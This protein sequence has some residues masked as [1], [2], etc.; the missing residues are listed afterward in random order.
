M[1][2]GH[3]HDDAPFSALGR[4]GTPPPDL[5]AAPPQMRPTRP[6]ATSPEPPPPPETESARHRALPPARGDLRIGIIGTGGMAAAHAE[7]FQ[8]QT[9]C[10]LESCLD[11]DAAAAKAFASRFAIPHQAKDVTDL[12]R[13]CDAVAVVTPDATHAEFVLAALRNN[14]H[15]LCEKPLTSSMVDAK[16]IARAWREA[17]GRGVIGMVNFSYR[18]A[19]AMHHAAWLHGEGRIGQLRHVTA[20]YFQGWLSETHEPA[21]GALWRLRRASGGG[22][23][24]DLGCHL[25]DLVTAVAGP[26]RRIHCITSNFPKVARDGKPFTAW[27]GK[28]LDADDSAVITVE[29]AAGGL[30]VLQVSRWATGRQNTIR[31]DFHGTRGA[32]VF[33][34]DHSYDQ[35]HHHE[36]EHKAWRTDH[37]SAAPSTWQRFV[38]AI[39]DGRCDQPDLARGVEI[40][41][42]LDAAMHSAEKGGWIEIEAG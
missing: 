21:G 30:G 34:L 31:A 8:R 27:Q 20:Q 33:D 42:Y 35:V 11:I 36:A 7:N 10:R 18:C 2:N 41:S 39:R 26:V 19:A 3:P 37:P 12:I 40:Q 9:G 6:L 1:A 4:I 5:D 38:Q 28:P 17:K 22:V 16:R 25:L 24:A 14:R 32:L 13:R 29:F 23:I 15:V